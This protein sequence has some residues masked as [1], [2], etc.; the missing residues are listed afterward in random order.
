[1]RV[2]NKNC[3]PLFEVFGRDRSGIGGD[4]T[5]QY[6]DTVIGIVDPNVF[7]PPHECE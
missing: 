4:T 2:T 7:L 3:V 1:M 5:N 6:W